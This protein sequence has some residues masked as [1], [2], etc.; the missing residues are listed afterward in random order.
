[1]NNFIIYKHTNLING[2]VYI[3][4]TSNIK[5]RWSRNGERYKGCDHFYSAIQQ[6]GWNNFKHEIIEEGLNATEADIREQYWIAY[7]DSTNRDKGY[8]LTTG[9]QGSAKKLS[10][11]SKNKISQARI[12]YIKD[13]QINKPVVCL[14]TQTRYESAPD[15]EKQ[16]GILKSQIHQC[17]KHYDSA[18]TAHGYHWVYEDELSSLSEEDCKNKI[19][20]IESKRV[21]SSESRA[22]MGAAKAKQILCINTQQ[23]FPSLAEA[24]RVLGVDSSSIS[25]V[26][27]GIQKSAKGYQFKYIEEI[28]END[29][30]K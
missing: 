11:E 1:M 26:C 24:G 7:Y 19:A 12:Q 2:K 4:L 18:Y 21:L 28:K 25:K 15:A 9:G 3:G 30:N 13:N 5:D 29:I 20:E 27:R 23:I 14:E 17:C 22:A 10:D 8:N 16:T 6:Y